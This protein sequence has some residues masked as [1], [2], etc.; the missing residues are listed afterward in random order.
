MKKRMTIYHGS[1]KI[2]KSP[3]FGAGNPNND[4]GTGFYCTE[5]EDLAK[6][7]SV[8]LGQDGY[9]NQYELDVT[10]VDV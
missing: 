9:A 8:S 2:I 3:V 1:K 7:W 4:Y 6:E 5:D 10:G